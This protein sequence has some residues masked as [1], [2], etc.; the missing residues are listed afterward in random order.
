MI[1]LLLVLSLVI[2]FV[3]GF[4]FGANR[5]VRRMCEMSSLTPHQL[6]Y[7]LTYITLNKAVHTHILDIAARESHE[8]QDYY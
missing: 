1:E 3:F 8:P 7:A 5:K 4:M 2:G 6:T